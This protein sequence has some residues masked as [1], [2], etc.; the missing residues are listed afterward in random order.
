MFIHV[1]GLL[2]VFSLKC[3]FPHQQ[4]DGWSEQQF[5]HIPHATSVSASWHFLQSDILSPPVRHLTQH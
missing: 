2:A 3:I 4:L 1:R 5:D